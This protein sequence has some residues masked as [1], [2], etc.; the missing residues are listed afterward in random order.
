MKTKIVLCK[1]V[2]CT[3]PATATSVCGVPVCLHH[4]N[5]LGGYT[6]LPLVWEYEQ[7]R[8]EVEQQAVARMA[9]RC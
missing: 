5:Y 9:P 3:R 8:V 1:V 4:G 2:P 6:L 7:Q